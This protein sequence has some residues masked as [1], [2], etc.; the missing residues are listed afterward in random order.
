MKFL[1]TIG[2]DEVSIVNVI[3]SLA[4]SLIFSFAL[5]WHFVTFGKTLSNRE[6]FS[7]A[8]PYITTTT[9]LIIIIVKSSLA[10]SLGLV[11]ALSII[12]FRTPIKEPEELAYLFIAIALGIGFG[13][14]YLLVT[15]MVVT[16]LLVVMARFS[17]V[18]LK[19]LQQHLYLSVDIPA[20]RP[21]NSVVDLLTQVISDKTDF[22]DLHRFDL[23]E[24]GLHVTYFVDIPSSQN[25]SVLLDEIS[26]VAPNSEISLLDQKRI[27]GV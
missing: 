20:P 16:I 11:G 12:R 26:V 14:N 19:S 1:E 2:S 5:R 23:R 13:A 17:H 4:L 22:C 7:S 6:N 8:F 10:L 15:S 9:M 21:D 18:R 3:F 27:P 24:E 25:L